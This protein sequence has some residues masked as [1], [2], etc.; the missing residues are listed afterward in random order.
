MNE[1]KKGNIIQSLLALFKV[2]NHWGIDHYV[3]DLHQF[4]DER[5][6]FNGKEEKN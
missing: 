3:D 2:F 6:A 1:L 5:G 4:L